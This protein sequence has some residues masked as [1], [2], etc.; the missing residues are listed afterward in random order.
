MTAQTGHQ[1]TVK[2]R[3]SLVLPVCMVI[4]MASLNLFL[5]SEPAPVRVVAMLLT[6]AAAVLSAAA[7]V[8]WF[9]QAAWLTGTQ[10]TVRGLFGS[11]RV[12]LARAQLN[13]VTA[14]TEIGVLRLDARSA[15]TKVHL[16]LAPPGLGV[17]PAADLHALAAAAGD[18]DVSDHLGHLA[19]DEATHHR[20]AAGRRRQRKLLTAVVTLTAV[21]VLVSITLL[22]IRALT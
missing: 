15:D 2:S 6:G 5:P 16:P 10:L 18:H 8:A 20:A 3:D 13:L 4:L 19:T 22:L 11:R 17:L 7:V 12:D 21:D 9:R 14:R 1:L